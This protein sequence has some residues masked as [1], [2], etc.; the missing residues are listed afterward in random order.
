MTR[1]LAAEP[2]AG[3]PGAGE[4]PPGRRSTE[5]PAGG[6]SGELWLSRSAQTR[7]PTR[8]ERTGTLLPGSSQSPAAWGRCTFSTSS[9]FLR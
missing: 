6:S 8:P 4:L 5:G 7:G 1:E 3:D 2:G 9:W